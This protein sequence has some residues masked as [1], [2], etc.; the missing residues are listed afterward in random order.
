MAN[1]T[2]NK[3]CPSLKI[4]IVLGKA[5]NLEAQTNTDKALENLVK[6]LIAF[7][8]SLALLVVFYLLF[9]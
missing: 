6:Y 1:S 8:A 5:W 4:K 3:P 2:N 9:R 7:F